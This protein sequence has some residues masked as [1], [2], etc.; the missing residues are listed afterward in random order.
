MCL[1][2]VRRSANPWKARQTYARVMG[3]PM[4]IVMIRK[5]VCDRQCDDY[6][7]S[8][9]IYPQSSV[10]DVVNIR[11]AQHRPDHPRWGTRTGAVPTCAIRLDV[12][13]R[14]IAGHEKAR[15]RGGSRAF[16]E[17]PGMPGGLRPSRASA[18]TSC[19]P[20]A[21]TRPGRGARRARA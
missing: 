7:T 11:C 19:G 10:S 3:A 12:T 9:F 14:F 8:S 2:C 21:S 17:L 20:V 6:P 4:T 16:R 13:A 18:S 5:E 15:D 1:F